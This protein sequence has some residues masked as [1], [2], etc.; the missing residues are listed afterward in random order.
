MKTQYKFR[1]PSIITT[2]AILLTIVTACEDFV[3]IDPP[4]TTLSTV[5]VF[6]DESTARAAVNRI[7]IDMMQSAGFAGGATSL[8][9]M[10]ALAADE[11]DNYSNTNEMAPFASNNVTPI[12]INIAAVWNQVY[13]LIYQANA[14]REGLEKSSTIS[15]SSKNQLEGEAQFMHAYLHFLLVSFWGDVP[16]IEST[17]YQKNAKAAR[18]SA[19]EIY[20]KVITE[21]LEAKEKLPLSAPQQIRPTKNAAAALLARVYLY[22]KNYP[23]AE[24]QATEL[25]DQFQLEPDLNNVFLIE[26][27]E[28]VFQLQSIMPRINTWDGESY[29]ILSTPQTVALSSTLINAFEPDDLRKNSWTNTYTE[30]SD[31]WPY[32]F[33][34]KVRTLPE[35]ASPKTEYQ[36]ILRIGE[37][38]LIRAEA[39]ANLDNLTASAEDVNAI[40]SRAGL[41]PIIITDKTNLL[42][43]IEQERRV[44]LFS[45]NGHRWLDLKR[46]GRLDAVIGTGKPNWQPTDALFPIPQTERN[47]N[48][49]LTQNPGY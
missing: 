48:N 40:R 44:E 4:Q 5:T 14:I 26:S 16:W 46:T 49:N 19:T 22:V 30:G 3:T 32:P 37:L 33:K 36:V 13:N 41:P 7:Y 2:I 1:N 20:E 35:A 23:A 47:R 39:R 21:L 8:N 25:I 29:V 34:Y 9:T 15:T 17:D 18:Q 6:S 12:N 31:T 11:M 28:T 42:M 43:A 38:Y 27:K 24:Q 45:E 10:A